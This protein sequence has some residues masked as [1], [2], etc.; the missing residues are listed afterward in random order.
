V[1]S[2]IGR[3]SIVSRRLCRRYE[4]HSQKNI[5]VSRA[6]RVGRVAGAGWFVCLVEFTPKLM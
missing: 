5:R 3:V 4:A 6:R 2:K 1:A